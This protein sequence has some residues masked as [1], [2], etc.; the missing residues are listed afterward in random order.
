MKDQRIELRLPQQQ[1][2]ELDNFIAEIDSQYKPSRSDVLRSFIA[3]GVQG[4]FNPSGQEGDMFPMAARLNI[5]F[6][7]CQLQRMQ[8]MTEN[9]HV[10]PIGETYLPMRDYNNN[11]VLNTVT[12]EALIRQIYLQRMTWFFELDETR[13]KSISLGQDLILSL[14]AP[15]SDAEICKSLDDVLALRK[16]FTQIRVVLDAAGKKVEQWNDENARNALARIQGHA[17]DNNLPLAFQGY[18]DT[19]VWT[20][21]IQMW[22]LL[23]WMARGEGSLRIADY[24]IRTDQDWS[25]KYTT[26]LEVYQD[27]CR[28]HQ[29]DLDGL[30][31]MVKDRRF[32]LL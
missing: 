17:K 4:K 28:D 20:L 2:E 22:A 18:P 13:L 11:P 14:M 25:V 12:A 6:Q 30:E 26:M 16:M 10:P 32:Y 19:D 15:Q 31:M 3:Q 1:L 23:D 9:R 21:Q 27:V 29:F 5:F 24:S 7:L 8:C